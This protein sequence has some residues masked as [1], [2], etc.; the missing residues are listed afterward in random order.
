MIL[1]AKAIGIGLAA[2]IGG[3]LLVTGIPLMNSN[4]DVSGRATSNNVPVLGAEVCLVNSNAYIKL[5]SKAEE[6]ENLN[7]SLCDTAYRRLQSEFAQKAQTALEKF[8]AEHKEEPEKEVKE[9]A[10]AKLPDEKE[11]AE[12]AKRV[13]NYKEY[14]LY[15]RKRA[16][17]SQAGRAMYE[18]GAE[19]WEAKLETLK[20][21]GRL[22]FD[23]VSYNYNVEEKQYAGIGD[24]P[25][26]IISKV[27]RVT[28]EELAVMNVVEIA[29]EKQKPAKTAKD[30]NAVFNAEKYINSNAVMQAA[31][32]VCEQ[33]KESVK[34]L[35]AQEDEALVQGQIEKVMSDDNGQFSF[36]NPA[37]KPGLYGVYLEHNMLTPSGDLLP[38]R[39][40]VPVYIANKPFSWNKASVVT[41]DEKN[42]DP[43][44]IKDGVAP[45]KNEIYAR[46][47]KDLKEEAAKIK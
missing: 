4:Y 9:S 40:V 13:K 45:Q 28:P 8:K 21:K 29:P 41:L 39:W 42:M 11:Q 18:R 22:V 32:Q 27:Q 24:E 20:E 33:I 37:I 19:F 47:M 2:L 26:Q 46:F 10:D 35:S 15:C 1:T 38:V 43:G 25:V 6:R 3:G 7:D 30:K 5:A 36:K 23:E 17:E 34:N 16:Q 12:I 14:A 44:I 31:A